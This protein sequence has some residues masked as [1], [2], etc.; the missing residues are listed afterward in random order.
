MAR[1]KVTLTR[2]LH[3]YPGRWCRT[4]A[5]GRRTGPKAVAVAMD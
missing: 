2:I 1:N 4:A 3:Q 5:T